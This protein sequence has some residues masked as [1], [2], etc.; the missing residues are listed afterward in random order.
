MKRQAAPAHREG[1]G[2]RYLLVYAMNGASPFP[3]H[4]FQCACWSL[5]VGIAHIKWIG[6]IEVSEQPLYSEYNTTR[7]VLTVPTMGPPTGVGIDAHDA[8]GEERSPF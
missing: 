2:G 4:G 7:Y 6:F 3:D 5:R 8:E 1:A